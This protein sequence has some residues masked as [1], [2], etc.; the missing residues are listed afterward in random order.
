M[1]FQTQGSRA[2]RRGIT[3]LEVLIS[4]GILAIGLS[5]VV[6]LIPAARSQASRAVVLDRAAVLAANALADAATFG[7]ILDGALTATGGAIILDPAAVASYRLTS[8]TGASLRTS[9]VFSGVVTGAAAPAV[10]QRLL[11]ESRDDIVV[12]P[13]ATAEDPPL[14]AFS[15][16]ARSYEGRMSCLYCL[17]PPAAPGDF[18]RLSVVVFHGRDP[19]LPVVDGVVS[20]FQ[21]TIPSGNTGGRPLKD[22]LRPGVVFW[23]STNG[24]FHQAVSASWSDTTQSASLT[25]SSGTLLA[26]TL[27][28]Q[29][30]PDSVGLAERPYLPE[31]PGPFTR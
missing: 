13:G 7:L 19:S 26:G 17:V 22:I 21:A 29:F 9:G 16:D 3:L 1:P 11:T 31:T 5:S 10:C 8:A 12:T 15:D 18:G 27:P 30:L 14:N 25:V 4:I 23:D 6:A 24:R 20:N 28:V 2:V